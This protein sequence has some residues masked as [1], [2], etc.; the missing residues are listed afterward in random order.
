MNLERQLASIKTRADLHAWVDTLP[1]DGCKGL[2]LLDTAMSGSGSQ[3]KFYEVGEITLAESL[4]YTKSF[5]HWLFDHY[6]K[7]D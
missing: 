4:W 5:E 6:G 1:E 7:D 2:I 3:I